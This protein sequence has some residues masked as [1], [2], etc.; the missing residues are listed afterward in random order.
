MA[1]IPNIKPGDL[2]R[3]YTKIK[4]G[5]KERIAPYQGVV[6]QIRGNA[7]N[8]MITVR[9]ISSGIGIERIFPISSP[10]IAKIE[11]KKKGKVRRAKL[12][13]LRERRGKKMKIREA[14]PVKKKQEPAVTPEKEATD[15]KETTTPQK[16]STAQPEGN[17]GASA[18]GPKS[19]ENA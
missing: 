15:N 4:E 7:G 17:T 12:N 14:A 11:I 18:A 3:V 1:K 6:I 19:V 2:V 5:D 13:Y 8:K 16:Q 10:L 9:K